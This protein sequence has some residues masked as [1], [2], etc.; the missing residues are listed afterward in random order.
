MASG[1]GRRPAGPPKFRGGPLVG[2]DEM[3]RHSP[4]GN[5]RQPPGGTNGSGS[6]VPQPSARTRDPI[7]AA[8]RRR[9]GP[10]GRPPG[11]RDRRRREIG[12]GQGRSA[13][14]LRAALSTSIEAGGRVVIEYKVLQYIF[15]LKKFL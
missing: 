13:G 6:P 5:P 1:C 15:Y 14:R 4:C 9:P 10:Q 7:A 11:G 3:D 12:R 2:E 8:A